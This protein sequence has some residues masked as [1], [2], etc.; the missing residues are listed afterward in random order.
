[1][2]GIKNMKA[3][4]YDVEILDRTIQSLSECAS[5]L[6]LTYNMTPQ[7]WTVSNSRPIDISC[8]DGRQSIHVPSRVPWP[9]EYTCVG[10]GHSVL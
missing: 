2:H 6:V 3:T 7:C 8:E 5:L 10:S 1:M 4:P 9:A